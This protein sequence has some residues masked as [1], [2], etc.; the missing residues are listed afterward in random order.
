MRNFRIFRIL[1]I[2]KKKQKLSTKIL[3][4]AWQHIKYIKAW[5]R[6]NES[7]SGERHSLP[8]NTNQRPPAC[9]SFVER[10]TSRW[11]YCSIDK[12]EQRRQ[13]EEMVDMLN[14]NDVIGQRDRH[15]RSRWR[16]FCMLRCVARTWVNYI[17]AQVGHA[18]MST[19]RTRSLIERNN[20]KK[21]EAS[22]SRERE[23]AGKEEIR[24]EEGSSVVCC[25]KQEEETKSDIHL[26]NITFRLAF[27][28]DETSSSWTPPPVD[29]F[30]CMCI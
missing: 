15:G 19:R 26:Y 17:N 3:R 6:V 23:Y 8:F 16:R 29:Y 7:K 27:E 18:C 1:I 14:G 24:K 4:F 9:S 13:N 28:R 25:W 12:R 30:N 20:N 5:T 2:I 11:F 22:R 21:R 10:R